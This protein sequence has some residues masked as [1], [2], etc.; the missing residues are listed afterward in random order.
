VLAQFLMATLACDVALIGI[1]PA[2]MGYN[3]AC[4]PEVNLAVD[5]VV[6]VLTKAL[7]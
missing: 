7:I 3:Q 2:T 4:S 6:D 5:S 1:Q